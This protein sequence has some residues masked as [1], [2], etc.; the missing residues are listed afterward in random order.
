MSVSK[1][2]GGQGCQNLAASRKEQK[3]RAE[4]SEIY[5]A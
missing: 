5:G 1:L 2:K 4:K 3:D